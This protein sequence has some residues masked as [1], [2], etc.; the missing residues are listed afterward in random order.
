MTIYL[1]I[2]KWAKSGH[3]YVKAF[4]KSE[5]ASGWLAYKLS[6]KGHSGRIDAIVVEDI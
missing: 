6:I 3:I 5:V 2:T 1:V 4:T